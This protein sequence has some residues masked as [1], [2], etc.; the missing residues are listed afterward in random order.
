MLWDLVRF[1]RIKFQNNVRCPSIQNKNY[2]VIK[3]S[4][5][6]FENQRLASIS[7]ENKK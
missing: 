5:R 6:L 2:L 1:Q 7:V 4:V 3:S